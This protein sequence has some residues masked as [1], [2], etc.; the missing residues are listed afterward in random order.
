MA[1][2]AADLDRAAADQRAGRHH[3]LHDLRPRPAAARVRRREGAAAISRCAAAAT[4]RRCWRS[5]ARPTRSTT[6]MCVIADEHGVE[7]LAGI[8]GGEATGCSEAT[9]D[10][11]IEVGAVERD[12]HRADRPQARHQFR[13]ALS[14]R[15]RRRSGLHAAGPRDGD[16]AWCSTSAAAR[17]RR[18]TLPATPSSDR[19]RHRFPAGR[20]EAARRYRGAAAGNAAHARAVSASWWPARARR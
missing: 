1:A 15:A 13:R 2:G 19:T 17:R 7:S 9:T 20:G 14:F 11:L 12:Q 4:A 16:P 10:V 3:Q 18:I 5:T 8:M 6:R